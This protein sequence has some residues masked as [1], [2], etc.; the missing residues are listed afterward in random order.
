MKISDCS[1]K[2]LRITG[3]ADHDPVCVFTATHTY[4]REQSNSGKVIIQC[5]GDAWAYFWPVIGDK[6]V[7]QFFCKASSDY[8][9]N[10]LRRGKE[11]EVDIDALNNLLR[12]SGGLLDEIEC[13]AQI[14]HDDTLYQPLVDAIGDDWHH[15]LPQKPTREYKH[16]LL[17]I[18][19]V[20]EAF[21]AT[22]V[23]AVA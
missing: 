20:K 10:K 22:N 2:G 12:D 6:T 5:L 18:E 23:E 21:N 8:I 7:E 4:V 15:R 3:V 19:S 13:E 17:I 11:T 1:M 9:A 16:L 14:Y